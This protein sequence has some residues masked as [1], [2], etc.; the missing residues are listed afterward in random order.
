LL[1]VDDES[2]ILDMLEDLLG[3]GYRLVKASS[4]AAAI[5]ALD[6]VP[7]LKLAIVD[8]MM[9]GGN[10]I[11]VARAIVDR[12]RDLPVILLSAYLASELKDWSG[13]VRLRVLSK[14]EGPE[15]IVGAVRD[16]IEGPVDARLDL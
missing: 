9:P 15:R 8:Y 3:D 6:R 10:G 1:V 11:D 14:S 7:D 16:L 5:S 2:D 4:A 12:K 13:D